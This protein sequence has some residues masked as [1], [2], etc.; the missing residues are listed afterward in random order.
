MARPRRIPTDDEIHAAL[1]KV[2]LMIFRREFE[3][4]TDEAKRE[5][6]D[7]VASAGN[8]KRGGETK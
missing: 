7:V 3:R 5:L 4:A 8:T 2:A 6:R 1:H